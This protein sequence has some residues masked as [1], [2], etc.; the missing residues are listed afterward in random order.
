M[1]RRSYGWIAAIILSIIITGCSSNNSEETSV[2]Y[3]GEAFEGNSDVAWGFKADSGLFLSQPLVTDETTYVGSDEKQYAI[4]SKTGELKWERPIEGT[5]SRPKLTNDALLYHD[6]VGLH[7][8]TA[9]TGEEKWN[10]KY[11]QPLPSGM[12]PK[13][14][15]AAPD[16][17]F[18]FNQSSLSAINISNGEDIW[19]YS[20]D[21]TYATSFV[22]D[23]DKVIFPSA[24]AV[25]IL[26]VKSGK[27]EASIT[28]EML[29]S[30]VQ[31]SKDSIYSVGVGSITAYDKDSYEQQW[32]YDNEAFAM[33]NQPALTVLDNKVIATEVQSGTIIALDSESGKELWNIQMGDMKYRPT[34]HWVIT[35]PAALENTLYIGAWGGEH[36][37]SKGAPAYSNLIAIDAMTGTEKWR[38][39]VNNFIMY[40]PA[41]ADGKLIVINMEGSIT[42]YNEGT[43]DIQATSSG[44][45]PTAEGKATSTPTVTK[46]EE[47]ST[48]D[49]EYELKDFEGHWM[50][51]KHDFHI[52]FTDSS[53]G[54]I[55]FYGQGD[56]VPEPFEF[57]KTEYD[58]VMLLVGSEQRPVSIRLEDINSLGFADEQGYDYMVRHDETQKTGDSAMD[59]ISRFEGKWCDSS[60]SYCFELKLTAVGEGV[61]DYY[62]E[63]EPYQESFRITYMDVYDISIDIE[64]SGQVF[65][66][67]SNDKNV[68]TYESDTVSQEM[69]RQS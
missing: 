24:G 12:Y 18:F 49:E 62:Q 40:A 39:Q 41:F 11:S 35:E 9:N 21:V 58:R 52:A 63:P 15:V 38:Y 25:K 46:A 69:T 33:T 23:D 53:Y 57:K 6:S 44:A 47:S 7:A 45:K 50:S 42:A 8:V 32:Q 64:G 61:L 59:L 56:E 43:T 68:L 14:T 5:P 65:L 13:V 34:Q 2:I 54:V 29:M 1:F 30:S 37:D 28:T 31:V 10:R 22:L 26:D 36:P 66:S 60:Q 4:D 48:E 17:A 20:G 19:E 16:T 67:L 55:T 51:D 3:Q 27:E